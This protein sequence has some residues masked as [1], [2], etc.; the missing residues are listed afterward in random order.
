MGA[1]TPGPWVLEKQIGT[2]GLDCGWEVLQQWVD[3]YRGAVCHVT[4]AENIDGITRDER[5][6]NAHL[7]AAAPYLLAAL[8]GW[9][10]H[11]QV[12]DPDLSAKELALIAAT[13][14]A[15]AKATP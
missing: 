14:A 15:I 6:A 2:N 5:D 8:Q 9:C 13:N 7:I 10:D 4:D 12:G 1:Y 11:L 3:G